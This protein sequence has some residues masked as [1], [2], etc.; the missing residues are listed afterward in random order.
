LSPIARPGSNKV[1][2]GPWGLVQ[3]GSVSANDGSAGE[4]EAQIAYNYSKDV[5]T[6]TSQV[7]IKESQAVNQP[8]TTRS[9]IAQFPSFQA[10]G[11]GL[12]SSAPSAPSVPGAISGTSPAGSQNGPIYGGGRNRSN[13]ID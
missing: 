13:F 4:Q 12:L 10:S 9:L 11:N 8:N 5:G 3:G 7:A 2:A 1:V 6:S